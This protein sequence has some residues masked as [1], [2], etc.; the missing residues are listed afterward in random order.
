LESPERVDVDDDDFPRRIFWRGRAI[1]IT[2]AVGPERLSGDWWN[3]G[4][5]RDYWRCE[6]DE[7]IGELVLYRDDAAWWIQGWYD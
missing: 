3:A 2:H 1:V 4:Y 6:S 5:S 7:D